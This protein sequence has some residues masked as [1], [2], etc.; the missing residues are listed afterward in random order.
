MGGSGN[1]E[2]K[3]INGGRKKF[4]NSGIKIKKIHK[5]NISKFLKPKKIIDTPP[6]YDFIQINYYIIPFFHFGV[7]FIY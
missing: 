6:L 4:R 5:F 1:G 3:K 2:T 7:I